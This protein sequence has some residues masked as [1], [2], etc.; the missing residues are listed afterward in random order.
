MQVAGCFPNTCSLSSQAG[1]MCASSALLSPTYSDSV[2]SDSVFPNSYLRVP[3]TY[4][5]TYIPTYRYLSIYPPPTYLPTFLP[6][7]RMYVCMYVCP[8]GISA[9]GPVSPCSSLTC[10]SAGSS[11]PGCLP[12]CWSCELRTSRFWVGA[13]AWMGEVGF[14]LLG[15]LFLLYCITRLEE[16]DRWGLYCK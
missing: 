1:E 8:C 11:V 3:T 5:P 13:C 16:K 2:F 14:C 15:H 6:T 4:L 10:G 7:S 12:G 9:Q